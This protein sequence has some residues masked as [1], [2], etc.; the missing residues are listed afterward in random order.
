MQVNQKMIL[1]LTASIMYWS[2]LQQTPEERESS[3][4]PPGTPDASPVP[5]VDGSATPLTAATPDASPDA[6]V[7]GS[8]SPLTAAS[9]EP[10]PAPSVNGDDE[11]SLNGEISH[12][13]TDDTVSETAVTSTLEDNEETS[14]LKKE[15]EDQKPESEE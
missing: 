3:P 14:D 15:D 1:T 7:N 9:P 11:G 5:S 4:A 10:S 12:M 13:S 6:S 2:L 8:T